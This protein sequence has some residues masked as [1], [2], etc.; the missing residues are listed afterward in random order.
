[1][2]KLQSG[3]NICDTENKIMENIDFNK[4]GGLV[5]VVIQDN[6]TLQVLMV[7]FMNE[8]AL[9]KTK[10]EGKVTFFSRSRNRLWTKGE[11]SGNYLYVKDIKTDCDSDA[12]LIKADLFSFREIFDQL[13]FIWF[14]FFFEICDC[15]FSCLCKSFDRKSLF[16]DL[17]HLFFNLFQV[18]I[19]QELLF[20]NDNF[21][22][23][24]RVDYSNIIQALF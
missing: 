16:D 5:P 10:E 21:Y 13:Y 19:E 4:A 23:F 2:K 17:L 14:V 8:E 18:I 9:M 6:I 24:A 3:N 1:M 15:F 20:R 7:G 22:N 11:T 12:L